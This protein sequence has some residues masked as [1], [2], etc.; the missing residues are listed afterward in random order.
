MHMLFRVLEEELD[1]G[2]AELQGLEPG[3][4]QEAIGKSA[5]FLAE[6]RSFAPGHE[7]EDWLAA[8]RQRMAW[9]RGFGPGSYWL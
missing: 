3:S 8:E 1:G 7:L 6:R 9:E 2:P 5:Y 4:R